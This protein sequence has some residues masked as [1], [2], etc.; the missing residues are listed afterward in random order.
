M[1]VF[2]FLS[3]K[4]VI[5]ESLHIKSFMFSIEFINSTAINVIMSVHEAWMPNGNTTQSTQR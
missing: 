1:D 5:N 2:P 3:Y 4:E